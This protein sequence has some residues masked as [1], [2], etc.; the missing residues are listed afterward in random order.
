V[1]PSFVAF[2][3]G[4]LRKSLFVV[5]FEASY[6]PL[7]PVRRDSTTSVKRSIAPTRS[8]KPRDPHRPPCNGSGF[9]AVA[10]N[11]PFPPPRRSVLCEEHSSHARID[12]NPPPW[13]TRNETL[14]VFAQGGVFLGGQKSL[15]PG[16]MKGEFPAP[17][18]KSPPQEGSEGTCL[19]KYSGPRNEAVLFL[20]L[21]CST[22][23]K[24]LPSLWG[25]FQRRTKIE[26]DI[27]PPSPG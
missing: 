20:L 12:P 3:S 15:A 8:L 17:I 4:E 21:W 1:P 25:L 9:A 2:F 5:E 26:L 14:R 23:R 19:A 10:G 11:G 18:P 24:G 7:P 22:Y 6:F 13:G 16:A 27:P